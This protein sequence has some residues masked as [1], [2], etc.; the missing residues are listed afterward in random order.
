MYII[1]AILRNSKLF[2]AVVPS[3]ILIL[4]MVVS[5]PI[6]PAPNTAPLPPLAVDQS[7]DELF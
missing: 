3:P 2:H 1:K 6:S 5:K 4:S 7:L